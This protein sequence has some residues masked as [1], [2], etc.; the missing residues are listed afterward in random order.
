MSLT[1]TASMITP[2]VELGTAPIF[3]KEIELDLGH[4]DVTSATLHIS[5]L[6][7]FEAHLNGDPVGDDVL[8]PGWTSTSGAC[9]TARTM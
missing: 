4:G 9:A 7:I 3:R 2:V 8:S 5:S 1:W 6:G